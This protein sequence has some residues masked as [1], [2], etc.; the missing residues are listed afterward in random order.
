MNKPAKRNMSDSVMNQIKKG[1][2]HMR[3]RFYFA[4][5]SIISIVGIILLGLVTSY[6]VSIVFFWFRIETSNT[7]AWGARAN[8]QDTLSTFPWWAIPALL[9]VLVLLAWIIRKQGTMYRHKFSTVIVAVILVSLIFGLT[10][11][12][13]GIGSNPGNGQRD[14]S[15]VPRGPGGRMQIR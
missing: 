6:M 2:V 13:L 14:S 4:A 12:S 7:M 3:P 8:L 11:S 15:G 1:D 5:L 9:V 10:M